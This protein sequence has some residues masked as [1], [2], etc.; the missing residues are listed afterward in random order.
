MGRVFEKRRKVSG[1]SRVGFR[2][3]SGDRGEEVAF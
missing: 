1:D 3:G 2:D